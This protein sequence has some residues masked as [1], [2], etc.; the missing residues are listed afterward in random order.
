MNVAIEPA[1]PDH[2]QAILPHLR[3]RERRIIAN[4]PDPVAAL[5]AE[6][7]HS[8]RAFALLLDGEVVCLWGV[9]VR[10][11]LANA[12]YIWL[13]TSRAVED[14]PVLFIRQS[15]RMREAL[16]AEYGTIEG[17]VAIDNP[18]SVR[19]LRWLGASFE[20]SPIDGMLDFTVRRAT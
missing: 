20:P 7:R 1:R 11:I 14:H 5:L 9:Q 4:V 2:V 17:F 15:R 18:L 6:V 19:W 12:V 16:L 8:S 3:D 13:L 10:S